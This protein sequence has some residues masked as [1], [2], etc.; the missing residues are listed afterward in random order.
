MIDMKDLTIGTRVL[1]NCQGAQQTGNVIERAGVE[2]IKSIGNLTYDLRV[3]LSEYSTF[4]CDV[5]SVICIVEPGQKV[6]RAST[7]GKI[8]RRTFTGSGKSRHILADDLQTAMTKTMD[9]VRQTHPDAKCEWKDQPNYRFSDERA[10]GTVE[11]CSEQ[12]IDT[13]WPDNWIDVRVTVE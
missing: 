8:G 6:F 1:V 4:L 5:D 7:L 2:K 10:S 11:L 12:I 9:W 13:G 3:K